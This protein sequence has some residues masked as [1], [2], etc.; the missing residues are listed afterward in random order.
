M[1]LSGAK[2]GSEMAAAVRAIWLGISDQFEESK[3]RGVVD[4][5][6]ELISCL[7]VRKMLKLHVTSGRD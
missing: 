1:T 2:I 3:G 7:E 6:C 5:V 4:R